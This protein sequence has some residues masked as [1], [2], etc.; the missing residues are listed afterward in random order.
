MVY[1]ALIFLLFF[2]WSLTAEWLVGNVSLFKYFFLNESGNI[3][4]ISF[5]YFSKIALNSLIALAFGFIMWK[6]GLMAAGDAKLFFVFSFLLPLRYYS[7]SYLPLFP[8][9]VLL[10]NIYIPV[11]FFILMESLYFLYKEINLW[12]NSK[13]KL[14][15]KKIF[16]LINKFSLKLT[17]FLNIFVL[18]IYLRDYLGHWLPEF[19][20]NDAILFL[21]FYLFRRYISLLTKNKRWTSF[22]AVLF[23]IIQFVLFLVLGMETAVNKL[24]DTIQIAAFLI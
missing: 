11:F 9:F 1:G 16:L 8:S 10:I 14:D 4:T 22:F 13:E 2:M 3:T 21:I 24:I 20:K 23:L 17:G 19:F 15:Y 12:F 5:N 18:A 6:Y 7:Q